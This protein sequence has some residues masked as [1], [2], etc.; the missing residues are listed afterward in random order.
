MKSD[1]KSNPKFTCSKEEDLNGVVEVVLER[2]KNFKDDTAFVVGLYG[3]LGS[4]KTTFTKY[5]AKALNIDDTITSPTFVLQKNFNID[6]AKIDRFKKLF[7]LDVY[8]LESEKELGALCWLE[9]INNPENIVL[10]EWPDIVEKA[11]PE[12]ILKLGFTFIN[13]TTREV[14]IKNA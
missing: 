7:H 12:N 1:D 9:I 2:A 4:G 3:N 8:R 10:I 6:P 11:M 13:E 5:L 14:E